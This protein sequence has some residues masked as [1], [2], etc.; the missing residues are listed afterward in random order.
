MTK[1]SNS[2]IMRVERV[3]M[4]WHSD[5]PIFASESFLREVGDEYGWI[6]ATD[7]SGKLR[8][9]L[10]YT[11]IKKAMFR[12]VRFRVET[13]PIGGELTVEEEK[14]FLNEVVDY[15]RSNGVDMIVPATTNSIFRTYPKGAL[16]AP[17]GTYIIDLGEPE[18][19][20]WGRIHGRN[21]NKIR[22]AMKNGVEIRNGLEYLDVAYELVR[23]TLM[24]SKLSFMS[25]DA[26]RR[27][28]LGLGENVKIFV[29]FYQDKVQG[30]AVLPY[31]RHSAYSVYAGS[32]LK[33]EDGATKLLHWVSMR[34]FRELGVR[35][36]DF[37][38]ARINPEKGSKQER[39]AQYKRH[40]G[41]SLV[42]GYMWKYSIRPARYAFYALAVRFLRGGDIV[43]H[44]RHKMSYA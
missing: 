20:I 34:M 35:R 10:P 22:K 39:L 24:R 27:M 25:R 23:A 17:Y 1:A 6:G 33:P 31:S 16:A 26:F 38:G 42:Q 41:G 18:D 13:I 12:M 2:L 8:C 29:A 43:D 4:N 15:F 7:S 3:S 28:I 14:L 30:C 21:R 40:L 11:V 19:K 9:I 5:L 36:Y 37:V 32:I 44:E